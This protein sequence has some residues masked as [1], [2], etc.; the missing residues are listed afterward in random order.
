MLG[1]LVSHPCIADKMIK[2]PGDVDGERLAVIPVK[3]FRNE[4]RDHGM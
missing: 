3:T 2:D 4:G 1:V